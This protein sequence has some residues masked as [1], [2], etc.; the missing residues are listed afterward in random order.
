MSKDALELFLGIRISS[1]RVQSQWSAASPS[2]G[3][4]GALS[5]AQRIGDRDLRPEGTEWLRKNKCTA[6]SRPD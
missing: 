1:A 5:H 3:E 4:F 2:S 6:H